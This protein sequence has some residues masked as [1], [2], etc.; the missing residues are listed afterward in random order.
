MHSSSELN[1][2]P[3]GLHFQFILRGTQRMFSHSPVQNPLGTL[4]PL[5]SSA[6]SLTWPIRPCM[7]FPYLPSLLSE[8]HPSM[9]TGQTFFQFPH[10]PCLCDLLMLP[11][12]PIP[13][14][15]TCSF[16]DLLNCLLSPPDKK[17]LKAKAR[18]PFIIRASAP[19]KGPSSWWMLNESLLHK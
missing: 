4:L 17:L 19:S 14:L 7:I 18:V 5:G 16:A 13:P 6:N 15:I 8:H 12:F 10:L 9:L 11:V 2:F 3:H 1:P